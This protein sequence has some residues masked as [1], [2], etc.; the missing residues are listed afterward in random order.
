MDCDDV[1]RSC[2]KEPLLVK[3]KDR[4]SEVYPTTEDFKDNTTMVQFS[5]MFHYTPEFKEAYRGDTTLMRRRLQSGNISAKYK[6]KFPSLLYIYPI[7]IKKMSKYFT[8]K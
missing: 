4:R 3:H 8:S 1:W 5:L 7:K 6:Q 2:K